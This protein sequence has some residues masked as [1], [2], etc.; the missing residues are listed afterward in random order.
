MA[1]ALIVAAGRGERLGS[2]RPKAL[3]TVSGRPMLAWSIEALRAVEAV[4]RIIVALPP[5]ALDAAPEGLHRRPG[6]E[7][8]VGVRARCARGEPRPRGPGDRARRRATARQDGAVRAG[9]RRARADGRRRRDRSG[10]RDGHDQGGRRRRPRR[11]AHARPLAAVGRPDPAGVPP[12][13]ARAGAGQASPELLARAT[14][15]AWLVERAGGRV[16]ILP[17]GA[18]NIKVTTP[19]DLLLAETLLAGRVG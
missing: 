3:V 4:E 7:R 15:D 9:A 12:R 13:R 6:R 16:R 5:E 2:G 8:P 14:D 10:G 1:V 17:A 19:R 11:R 18:E